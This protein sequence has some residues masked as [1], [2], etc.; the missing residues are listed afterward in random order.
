MDT[1]N[2]KVMTVCDGQIP[3]R[4]LTEQADIAAGLVR[5]T[6][7]YYAWATM[8]SVE[9]LKKKNAVNLVNASLKADFDNGA[10]AVMVPYE[11]GARV[12]NTKGRLLQIDDPALEPVLDFIRQDNKTLIVD[13]S[14]PF[15]APSWTFPHLPH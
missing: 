14:A 15:R 7:R 3:Y 4:T 6:P 10:I 2:I 13:L 5:S 8:F 1:F 11:I 9:Q 12:F